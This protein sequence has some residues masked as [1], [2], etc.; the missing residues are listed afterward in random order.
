MIN[1]I[2]KSRTNAIVYVNKSCYQRVRDYT[3]PHDIYTI[4]GTIERHEHFIKLDGIIV[5]YYDALTNKEFINFFRRDIVK[6]NPVIK[7]NSKGENKLGHTAPFPELIPEFAIKMFSY[8]GETVLDPFGGSLT[9]VISAFKN[10]RVG[11]AIE[12][13]KEMFRG[14]ILNNLKKTINFNE[15]KEFDYGK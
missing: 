15:I 9:S 1:F 8:K 11:I 4:Y 2:K 5:Y 7:I 13:N 6:I 14:A 3:T 12:L 10:D